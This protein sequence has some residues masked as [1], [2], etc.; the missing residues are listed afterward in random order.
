MAMS[1]IN[2]AINQKNYVPAGPSAWELFL[3]GEGVPESNCASLLASNSSK[4]RAIHSWVCKNYSTRY[5]PENI[6][7]AIGL[8]RRLRLR[9]Q[10]NADGAYDVPTED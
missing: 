8:R 10:R 3:L 1:T 4:G 7:E 2:L 6:L 5:V 9:W